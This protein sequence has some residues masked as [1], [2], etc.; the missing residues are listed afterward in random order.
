MVVGLSP[1]EEY[2]GLIALIRRMAKFDAFWPFDIRDVGGDVVKLK[3]ARTLQCYF[4]GFIIFYMLL[5]AVVLIAD[6]AQHWGD[7]EKV[8]ECGL[9]A[10]SFVLII[11]RL[12]VYASQR[13]NITSVI[14]KMRNDWISSSDEDREIYR[15][16]CGPAFKLTKLFIM[17]TSNTIVGFNVIPVIEVG[18]RSKFFKSFK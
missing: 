11:F 10:A 5:T 6:V 4:M 18:R 13:D 3:N 2:D 8:T 14:E 12:F 16:K 7:M 1:E 17:C 9:P 15:E